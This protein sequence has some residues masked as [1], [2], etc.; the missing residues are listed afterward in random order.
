MKKSLLSLIAVL[1]LIANSAMS[2]TRTITGTVT[3]KE[4]GLPIPGVNILVKGSSLGAQTDASGKY[5]IALPEGSKMLTFSFIGYYTKEVTVGSTNTVNISLE[6]NSKQLGEVVVVGYGIQKR[7]EFTGSA[8]TV[9]GEAFKEMPVQSF[10]QGLAGKATGVSIVQ[11]NGLLNNPPVIRVR[12]VN[13]IS[14]SSFPLVVVD[15]IQIST[16]DLSANSST[17]NPLGDINPADIESVDILKDAASTS[18]YGS[19]AAAGVLIITTKKGK[20]GN[21]KVNYDGWYGVNNAVRLPELL[22]AQQYID[23]KNA[24]LKRALALNPNA[25]PAAQRDADGK[26]FFPAYNADGSMIDT[27]W[28]D[29]IYRTAYSQNHN[30]N[31]SGGTDRTSYFFS[32]GFTD[33]DG[34]LKANEFN[35]KTGR[36]T[37]SHKATNWLK[38]S[39]GLSYANSFNASPNSGSAP[40]AAFNS[41]GLGRIAVAMAPNVAPYNAD[42][43][44]SVASNTIG[45]GNNLVPITWS[46]PLV[47]IDKDKNSSESNRFMGNIGAEIDLLKDLSFKSVYSLDRANVENLQ[48]WNPLNGDGYAYSGRAYNNTAKRNNWNFVNTLQYKFVIDTKH[49][50]SAMIGSEAQKTRVENWGAAREGVADPFFVQFQGEYASNVAAGNSI[51][52]RMYTGYFSS[53]S[54]NYAGKYFVSGNFRRDGNSALAAQNRWGN[55]GGASLG[56]T[57]SEEDFYKNSSIAKAITSARLKASWGKVGNGNLTNDYGAYTTFGAGSYGSSPIWAFNQAGNEELKWET[58]KQTNIGVDLG[59]LNDRITLEA[60]YYYN[61]VDNL[62]LGVPQSPSKGI[63][64]NSI[65]LNVGSMYN[66]GFEF[67]VNAVPVRTNKFS[68][69]TNLNV[70]LNKNEVTSLVDDNTPITQATGGLETSSITKVGYP[71]SSIFAVKTAGVNPE[72]GR[73]IFIN[74]KGE[75]VQYLHHGGAN[76]WTYLDGTKAA[77]VNSSDA[78]VLGGSLPTWYGGFNNTFQYGNFD[79]GVNFTFSGGNYIYNGSKAGLRDQRQWNN[80]VEVLKAWSTPNQNAEIPQAIYGDNVSNGSSF[81][82]DANVEK[83]DFLRLQNASLGYR[84]PQSAFGKIGINSLR[85]Y[86]QVTNAFIITKYTGVDPEIST[87][88]NDQLA[89]G[90]ERN[91]IPQGRAF[92]FGVS[93]GF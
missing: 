75:K 61:N 19:R 29:Q 48:F 91:S 74:K 87:N 27:K 58:S 92:T 47:L 57:L 44:Y 88:G 36:F 90:V 14:L 7:Q 42:G 26:S 35:R 13:S 69:T 18:I 60:N 70:T 21:V 23:H 39:T 51:G 73:R 68:W 82:I 49:N 63:P 32:A 16:G 62:I 64:N 86:A 84:I 79:L 5:S 1:L 12:G 71:V 72:N 25:V 89:G 22:N 65:L 78:Q 43:S 66:K 2:Q 85:V 54:Y 93:V 40:G 17:N 28:Y 9:K 77:A 34:F 30:I 10:G 76:A 11:P 24:A 4:D 8:A 33:Q 41:S 6:M 38:L 37:M 81:P 80:S 46:N 56:W 3:A 59:F 20:Q 67:G 55:F 83:G 50:F 15:G 52:E 53:L 31:V 45:K